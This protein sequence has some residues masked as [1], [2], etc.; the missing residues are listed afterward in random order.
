[1]LDIVVLARVVARGSFA[2]AAADLGVPPSTLSRKVI[3]LE[4]RLG[5]RLLERTTRQLRPTDVGLL[6]AQRGEQIRT[7]LDDVDRLVADH[8][9]APR[10]VLRLTVPTP[11]ASDLMA[12]ILATYLARYPEMRVEVLAEDRVVDLLTDNFDAAIRVGPL[13]DSTL[14]AIRVGSV[15]PVLAATRAYLDRAP[16]LRHPRDLAAHTTIAYSRARKV[17]WRF[18]RP[19][20]NEDESIDLTARISAT[21]APLVLQLCAASAGLALVPRHSAEAA[22][23]EVLAPAGYA[24]RGFDVHIVTPSAQTAPPKVRAFIDLVREIAT[25][26]GDLFD[27]V[28]LSPPRRV[29]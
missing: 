1:M 13:T 5:V 2:R 29:R 19:T 17:T 11:V 20:T 9:R 3:A 12:P 21:S 10:G 24:P 22:S 28:L 6:L 7:Q 16:P 27:P 4:R 23:L 8:Q 18:T 26:R 14:G 25:A 15:V